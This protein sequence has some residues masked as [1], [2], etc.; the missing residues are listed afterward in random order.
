MYRHCPK[1]KSLIPH[2]TESG[3]FH[4]IRQFIRCFEFLRGF[5]QVGVRIARTFACNQA[6]EQWNAIF[7]M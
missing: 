2:I 6:S 1:H 3:R 5:W 4:E 7:Q